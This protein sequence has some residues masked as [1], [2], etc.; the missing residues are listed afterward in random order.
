[1]VSK[2]ACR[3]LRLRLRKDGKLRAFVS[4]TTVKCIKQCE[5][6]PL[7]GMRLQQ[8]LARFQLTGFEAVFHDEIDRGGADIAGGVAEAFIAP[9]LH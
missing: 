8:A 4:Q 6:R 1:M 9:G 5:N 3:D 2:Q 7:S